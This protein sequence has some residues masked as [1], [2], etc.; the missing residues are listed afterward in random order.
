MRGSNYI[1]ERTNGNKFKRKIGGEKSLLITSS[2][3]KIFIVFLVRCLSL[4]FQKFLAKE[5]K[6][7]TFSSEF[8]I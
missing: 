3:V 8:V 6:Q 4:L 1:K 5:S 2:H 7:Y